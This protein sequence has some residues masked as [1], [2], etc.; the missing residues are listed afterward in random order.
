MFSKEEVQVHDSLKYKVHFE[1]C[2]HQKIKRLD[3]VISSLVIMG[4]TL[5]D[6]V[7]MQRVEIQY[8]VTEERKDV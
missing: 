5:L 8:K 4:V 7:C 2:N 6:T 1:I 3:D